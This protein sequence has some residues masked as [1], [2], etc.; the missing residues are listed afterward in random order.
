[1]NDHDRT[2]RQWLATAG[3][4]MFAAL[5]GAAHGAPAPAPGIAMP[6]PPGP[7]PKVA[8]LVHPRMILLDLVGP[9]TALNILRADI[10]TV[11]K[12]RTPCDTDVGIPVTARS[13]FDDCPADLDVL[14]VP[15]GLMGSIACMND[16]AVCAFLADRGAR[17]RYVTSVCTGSLVLGAA[18]LLQGHRATSHWAVADLLPLMGAMH[19]PGRVVQDRNRITGGGVTAGIDFGL[20]LAAL[21]K[22]EE[23]ARRIQLTIEY[24]PE[25]PFRNGTPEEAGPARVAEARARRP[26]MDAQAKA[27]A[28][29][30]GARLGIA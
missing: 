2:R 14:F 17:A 8:M 3:G 12:D 22:D 16:P 18:G 6:L 13:T 4:A 25:P 28:Q 19:V 9:L 1:M 30:A 5:S 29:A 11:W 10:H 21:L 26:W 23:E 15:G 24:A 20:T 27:A 7:Q